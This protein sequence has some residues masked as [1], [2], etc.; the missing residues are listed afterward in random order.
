LNTGDLDVQKDARCVAEAQHIPLSTIEQS[1][2][3]TQEKEGPLS[4][5]IPDLA[6]YA[7]VDITETESFQTSITIADDKEKEF[8]ELEKPEEMLA[9]TNVSGA[10]QSSVNTQIVLGN[11]T[12]D[13]YVSSATS[14]TANY[15]H[16]LHSSLIRTD[17]SA[18]EPETSFVND[19]LPEQRKAESTLSAVPVAV[20]TE[21]HVQ[22]SEVDLQLEIIP[23]S[24]KANVEYVDKIVA[25]KTQVEAQ[26]VT[27][28]L[29]HEPMKKLEA[30]PTHL[31]FEAVIQSKEI[32]AEK[33][34]IFEDKLTLH[35]QKPD[36]AFEL[37]KHVNIS[38][39]MS[40][41]NDVQERIEDVIK[42][43]E[44]TNVVQYLPDFRVAEKSEI[45]TSL[46][47]SDFNIVQE[48]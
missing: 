35:T 14:T 12:T 15:E 41:S 26:D 39:V 20:K 33:E 48:N 8:K 30:Q 24:M 43:E 18:I 46:Q 44:S 34:T 31:T 42:S 27:V 22:D 10:L 11:T 2:C 28:D 45:V 16:T 5:K 38:E 19:L 23:D 7:G 13:L 25:Q 6:K 4:T 1:E 37:R 9:T 17:I 3:I 29:T 32:T 21:M 47:T 40:E 36:I